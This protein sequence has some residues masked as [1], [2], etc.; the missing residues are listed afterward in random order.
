M[1]DMLTYWN[2][3]NHIVASVVSSCGITVILI[4]YF[5][6]IVVIKDKALV[7]KSAYLRMARTDFLVWKK[8]VPNTVVIRRVHTRIWIQVPKNSVSQS[9]TAHLDKNRDLGVRYTKI[10]VTEHSTNNTPVL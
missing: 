2:T 1:Q 3:E 9:V 4:E 7:R 5:Q 6:Y 10:T 8:V